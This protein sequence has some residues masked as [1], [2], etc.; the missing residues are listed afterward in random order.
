[1]NKEDLIKEICNIRP[2]FIF[3]DNAERLWNEDEEELQDFLDNIKK[4]KA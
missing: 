1:M 4:D 3:G 2:H